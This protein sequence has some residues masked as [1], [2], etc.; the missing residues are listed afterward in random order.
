M[1]KSLNPLN[2]YR[3]YSVRHILVAYQYSQDAYVADITADIGVIGT[4]LIGT[5][6]G[7]KAVVLLN[8]FAN[9][10]ASLRYCESVWSFFSPVNDRTTS[11]VGT[12][13]IADRSG[14]LFADTLKKFTKDLDTS[15]H[16]LTMVWRPVFVCINDKT[17]ETDI[18]H[19]NP[20]HF[21]VMNFTQNVTGSLFKSYGIEFAA[22]YNTHGLSPQ[23][24][25][26]YQ[27]TVV[28]SDSNTLNTIP[29]PVG[30]STGI[31]PTR[32]ENEGKLKL[33]TERLNKTKYMSTLGEVCS[34]LSA[35]LNAQV[36]TH[37]KQLQKFLSIIRTN[38]T[39]KV[40]EVKSEHGDLPLE[41]TIQLD[42]YYKNKKIDNRNLPFE[43]TEIDQRISGISSL[44]L[45][46]G[47]NI[48]STINNIMKMS[49]SVANDYSTKKI[50]SYKL[51]TTTNRDCSGKYKINIK[52]CPYFAAY[53]PSEQRE[54]DTGPGNGAIDRDNI[55]EYSYQD[56]DTQAS[57]LITLSYS[58]NP[59]FNLNTL[60][61][62][63][64]GNDSS[65]V[66]ADREPITNERFGGVKN[67][68][69]R[70][71]SGLRSNTGLYT[72]TGLE[73][74]AVLANMTNYKELQQTSYTLQILGNPSILNDI[75]RNPL[76]VVSN[77]FNNGR[78]KHIIY[79]NVE[80][81][82]MYLKLKIYL[83]GSEALGGYES[84]NINDLGSFY[85]DGYMHLYK[86]QTIF[87]PSGISQYLICART[88]ESV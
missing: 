16:H 1:E 81:E 73:N 32:K 45:P 70:G 61:V 84:Q 57:N 52:V 21:H 17:G 14:F 28:G 88:E 65:A 37:K 40:K 9:T 5:E 79:G 59:Q 60:E 69:S 71:L 22:A 74:S 10:T 55:L 51:T 25:R 29:T 18:I 6:C 67:F 46:P 20:L 87:T 78:G 42:N 43:Q 44:T 53:N 62:L 11:Y 72:N 12:M 80:T 76:D 7:G 36:T 85:Y 48:T 27:S 19:V 86:I 13:E 64:D 68:F 58:S 82:P 31:V 3:T 77:T 83:T 15:V 2:N 8:E 38:Y 56:P 30:A 26:I 24:S 75:N 4:K 63:E 50:K 35:S 41:Y 54:D 47:L 33:R 39:E 49:K 34:G 23:F 66:Y